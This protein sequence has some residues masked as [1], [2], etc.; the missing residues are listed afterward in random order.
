[1]TS[2]G[3]VGRVCAVRQRR[4]IRIS[5]NIPMAWIKL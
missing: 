2:F 1:M 5:E 4:A 3:I